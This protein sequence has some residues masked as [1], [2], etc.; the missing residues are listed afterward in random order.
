M[1][2]NCICRHLHHSFRGASPPSLAQVFA[3][4]D[5]YRSSARIVATAASVIAANA[6]WA[7]AGL[8]AQRPAGA[9]IEVGGRVGGWAGGRAPATCEAAGS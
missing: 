1:H 4:R 5:N 3:L 6:D 9:P 2:I 8:V 7:R